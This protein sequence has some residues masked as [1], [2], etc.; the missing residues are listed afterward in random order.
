MSLVDEVGI[1]VAASVGRNLKVG[2]SCECI[3]MYVCMDGWMDGW[4][5]GCM[6][7][8]CVDVCMVCAFTMFQ[9]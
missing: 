4:M 5:D 6:Y 3:H 2:D 7:V 9:Y 1:E 8:L